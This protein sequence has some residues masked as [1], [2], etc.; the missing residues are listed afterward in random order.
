MTEIKAKQT[1]AT[2]PQIKKTNDKTKD[3]KNRR[4][5]TPSLKC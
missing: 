1:I 4:I 2:N 5:T 3:S